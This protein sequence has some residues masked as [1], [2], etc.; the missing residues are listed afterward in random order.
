MQKD[1]DKAGK[2]IVI[3]FIPQCRVKSGQGCHVRIYFLDYDVTGEKIKSFESK[4]MTASNRVARL[5]KYKGKFGHKH[6]KN[7]P[8]KDK[9]KI[10]AKFSKKIFVINY[11]RS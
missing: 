5:K 6:F 1:I 10:E 4:K 3:I 9:R 11:I 7:L 8:K 2:D